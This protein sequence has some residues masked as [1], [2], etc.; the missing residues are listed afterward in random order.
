MISHNHPTGVSCNSGVPSLAFT[1]DCEQ[2]GNWTGDFGTGN[3]I[4]QVNSGG[5]A[6]GGT[7]PDAAHNGSSYF[8]YESSTFGG[9]GASQFDTATIISPQIDLTNA[10][11]GAELSFWVHARGSSMGTL[12]VGLSNSSSGPFNNV[13]N[14]LGETHLAETLSLEPNR[15]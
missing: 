12:S 1:D 6:S 7:G 8:Y 15:N 3:G 11:D 5:T 4:W 9:G 14:Q 2:Q 13:Y 10:V